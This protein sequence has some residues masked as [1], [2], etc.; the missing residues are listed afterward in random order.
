MS[1]G[2]QPIFL[3]SLPRSGSTLLQRLLAV[4]DD[5]A[6]VAEPWLLMPQL[7]AFRIHGL[8]AEYNHSWVVHALEDFCDTLPAGREDYDAAMRE[9]VLTLYRKASPGNPRYFLDKTP[10]YHL[11]VEEILSLFAS[12]GKF[13]VLWRN[14]LAVVASI[15]ETFAAG[16][17]NLYRYNVDLYKGLEN[18]IRT[19]E[20]HNARICAVR[21]EDLIVHPEQELGRILAYLELSFEP[22]VLQ[23][24]DQV[25]FSGRMGDQ[26]WSAA[27]YRRLSQ[28]PLEK[29][30]GTLASPVRKA[31]CRYYLRWIGDVR[32][33]SMGYEL[34]S[35]LSEL[36]S[37]PTSL[38][39]AGSDVVR[40]GYGLVHPLLESTILK[41]KGSFKRMR[42]T[43]ESHH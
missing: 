21:Y 18:L 41:E 7:Y 4:H 34:D 30:K 19:Y 20:K 8:H 16:R 25:R 6:T 39:T 32:L 35:L 31:W 12:D 14:P 37:T 17:W 38:R 15:M 9:F 33:K 23:R 1:A 42:H 40:S 26:S 24:F 22:S 27:N 29:W 11:V 43:S 2:S 28:E 36:D 5:I 13:I 3:F 10:R